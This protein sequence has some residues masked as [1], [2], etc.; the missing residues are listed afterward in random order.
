MWRFREECGAHGFTEPNNY[1]GSK[2]DDFNARLKAGENIA[3][4]HATF[5]NATEETIENIRRWGYHLIIDEALDPLSEF[6]KTTV[7]EREAR[8]SVNR[9]DL[10]MLLDN[11]TIQV[12]EKS[13]LVTWTGESYDG[14][15]YSAVERMAKRGG[16]YLVRGTALFWVF[17]PEVLAAFTSVTVMTF[18]F[19]GS[20][21]EA[22]FLKHGIPYTMMDVEQIGGWYALCEYTGASEAVFREQLRQLV[23]VVENPRLN[24]EVT[25]S[26]TWYSKQR[27]AEVIQQL[28]THMTYSSGI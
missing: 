4:T 25:L 6:N 5:L 17:R 7:V 15:K 10:K 18:L 3:V 12:E 11:K 22:Y 13:G 14:G 19:K 23:T 16:L 27:T 28:K 26:K 24:M 1:N 9:Q 20:L 2:I 8:Q 21:L